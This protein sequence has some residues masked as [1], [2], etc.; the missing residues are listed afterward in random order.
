MSTNGLTRGKAF[1]TRDTW[2]VGENEDEDRG[3][4]HSLVV[5]LKLAQFRNPLSIA[6]SLFLAA[7][8]G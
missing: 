4:S 2:E 7:Q 3:G 5:H 6:L 8:L 1:G